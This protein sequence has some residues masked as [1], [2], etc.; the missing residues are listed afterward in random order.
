MARSY[1]FSFSWW[2]WEKQGNNTKIFSITKKIKK[3][4]CFNCSKYRKFE[5]A[6]ISHLLGTTLVIFIIC[7]KC[8]NENEKTSKEEESIVIIKI[9]SSIEHIKLLWKYE[10]RI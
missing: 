7:S 1:K 4:Y 3:P 9:F 5:T 8:K 6:K 10:S 2:L